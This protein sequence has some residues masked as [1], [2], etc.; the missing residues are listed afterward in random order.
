MV[1]FIGFNQWCV[2]PTTKTK[3][4]IVLNHSLVRTNGS[5]WKYVEYGLS[6]V[7]HIQTNFEPTNFKQILNERTNEIKNWLNNI[8]DIYIYEVP[9]SNWCY[10]QWCYWFIRLKKNLRILWF[11]TENLDLKRF[12]KK[13]TLKLSFSEVRIIFWMCLN[14]WLQWSKNT[15]FESYEIAKAN[16]EL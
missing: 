5:D 3:I 6:L 16:H 7:Y 12:L 11:S 13:C 10:H 4:L 15:I 8:F 2:Y 9:F 1:Q 14:I